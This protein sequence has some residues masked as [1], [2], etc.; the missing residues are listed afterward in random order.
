MISKNENHAILISSD[1]YDNFIQK[2]INKENNNNN[3]DN[4]SINFMNIYNN[5]INKDNTNNNVLYIPSFEIKS[6]IGKIV[7]K[8]MSQIKHIIYIVMKIII[9]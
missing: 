7:I 5:L 8:K 2:F 1:L 9:I 4:I 6:K 3:K